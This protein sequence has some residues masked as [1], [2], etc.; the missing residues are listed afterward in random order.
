LSPPVTC[1][2]LCQNVFQ[3]HLMRTLQQLVHASMRL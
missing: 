3:E 2:S 1:S